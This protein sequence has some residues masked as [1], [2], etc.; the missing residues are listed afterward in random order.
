MLNFDPT[1]VKL[2]HQFKHNS[3]LIGCRFDPSGRFLF[4]SAQDDSL[5][6][7]DLLSGSKR[8]L[9]GL[10]SWSRGMAF[11]ASSTSSLAVA[12]PQSLAG[13]WSA[14]VPPPKPITLVSGD[15]HGQLTWWN[16]ADAEPKPIRTVCAHQ[17]WLRALAVSPDGQ[18]IAS[19][20]NDQLVRLW[21]SHDGRLVNTFEGHTSH[22]YNVAFH[23]TEPRLVSSELKGTLKDWNLQSG[24][25]IRD[26]DLKVL[27]KY[28][29]GF[30]ADIGGCRGLNFN[31]TGT[32][33]ACTGISNV[34]NAF[35]GVGNPL[36]V[37]I[38]WKTGQTTPLKTKDAFQ[39][40]GWGV[41]FHPSGTIVAAGGGNQGRIWFWKPEDNNNFHTVNVPSNCR[42]MALSPTGDLLGVAG[43][44]GIAYVYA[45]G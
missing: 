43:F 2:R 35:A 45:L 3:P 41:A 16:A 4:V 14:T 6:R 20:G 25:L 22:V 10:K 40:T 8:A 24:K 1:R 21:S 42:D 36:V 33:L 7:F 13:G 28:D 5:Q 32:T 44:T 34:S 30:E 15:Y 17:G 37:L 12:G 26:V 9:T 38:N 31:A 29:S 27:H 19:C 11:L 18:L 23:P 39:G